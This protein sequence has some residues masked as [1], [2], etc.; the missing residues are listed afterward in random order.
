MAIRHKR[1]QKSLLQ[2]AKAAAAAE[3][4]NKLAHKINNPLQNSYS[5]RISRRKARAI[6]MRK[7]WDNNS[8]RTCGDCRLWQTSRSRNPATAPARRNRYP[9]T[10]RH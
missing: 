1:Q 5:W 10:S 6:T 4:A 3:M 9:P 2:Q 8:P 7:L